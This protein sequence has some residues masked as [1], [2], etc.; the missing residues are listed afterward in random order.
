MP[1]RRSKARRVV[2]IRPYYPHV[3][4]I[5]G[6]QP[7]VNHLGRETSV[8]ERHDGPPAGA[9][10]ASHLAE[11]FERTRNIA[12]RFASAPVNVLRIAIRLIDG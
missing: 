2:E 9:Q 7:D 1:A 4:E 11:D 6:A 3:L 12:D 10:Y 5:I 8:R